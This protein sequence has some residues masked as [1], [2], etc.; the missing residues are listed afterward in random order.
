MNK[1]GAGESL[2]TFFMIEVVLGI[3][4]ASI[5]I[6][7]AANP[8]LLSNVNKIYA[9]QDISL[10][11]ETIDTA[12]GGVVYDYTLKSVYSVKLTEE[13]VTVT[14]SEGDLFGGFNY[15]NV[16]FEKEIGSRIVKVKNA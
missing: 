5:F 13:K 11:A 1:R 6:F 10:L 4:I 9:Q 8:D 7:N 12:P 15:Y 14:K 16:T 2:Q 3:L